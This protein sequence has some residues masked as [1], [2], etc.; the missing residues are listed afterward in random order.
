[1]PFR[2]VGVLGSGHIPTYR[3]N[4]LISLAPKQLVALLAAAGRELFWGL[5]AVSREIDF[6]RRRAHAIPN[7]SLRECAVNSITH[8]RDNAE[9]AALFWILPRRRNLRLLRLLVAYQTIWD[10]LDNAT[11][12]NVNQADTRQMHLA[13]VEALD[14]ESAI[15]DYY[16]YRHGQCDG[17]YLQALVEACR[18]GCATL[19]SYPAVRSR[20]LAGVQ[21]C[22]IQGINHDP[23]PRRRDTELREW[24]KRESAGQP[25]IAWFEFAAAASAFLP[26]VLLALAG[27]S[28]CTEREMD[29]ALAAYFP[30]VSLTIA[31]L[32]SYA[33]RLEDIRSG[34][35][36]YVAHYT[37]SEAA[38]QRI[39]EIVHRTA[40]GVRELHNGTRHAILVACMFAMHLSREGAHAT[41]T[42]A[43]TRAIA[44][45]GGSLTRLLLP[46]V[47]AWRSVYLRRVS[48][49]HRSPV[50][51]RRQPSTARSAL[52]PGSRLPRPIQT[53]VTWRWPH[54]RLTR[55][56][57]RYGNR[58]TLN[59]TSHPPLVFLSDPQDIQ[60]MFAAPADVLHPGEGVD[61]IEP[62]VG[63]TSFMLSDEEEHLSGR[64][65]ILPPFRPR[66]VAQ[67]EGLIA[68]IVSRETSSWPVDT[69]IAL[70]QRLRGLT[71]RTLLRTT[72]QGTHFAAG[73]AADRRLD[74][75]HE[76]LLQMLSITACAVFPEPLLRRGPGRR[77]WERFLRERE[78]V[79]QLIY[80]MVAARGRQTG[81]RGESRSL[82]STPGP[83]SGDLLDRLMQARNADGSLASARQV[84]DNLMSLILAGHETTA[85][86]LAWAFQLLAHN[87]RV[88]RRLIEEIDLGVGDAYLTATVQEVLRHRPVFLFAIPR[89]IKQPIEIGGWTYRPPAQLLACTYLLHHDPSIYPDPD[90]FRPERFLEGQ[91]AP[92]TWMPWGGGRK[93]CPGSHL[94]MLEMKIVLRT[95][96]ERMT[97]DP[98][99]PRM[100]RPRW[101]SVIVTPHAGGRVV[102]RKR[103]PHRIVSRRLIPARVPAQAGDNRVSAYD[104]CPAHGLKTTNGPTEPNADLSRNI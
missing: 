45:S 99:S 92:D 52:P 71:L 22:A 19:P 82:D 3:N 77:R 13:L 41:S 84:R 31:M 79:D 2:P 12:S 75:L 9:G 21:M 68:E 48:P 10:Y 43:Q 5:G 89:T 73:E 60:A 72:F 40:V 35:H 30:W 46:I 94:A 76:E 51:I 54:A 93:R 87:P 24:A 53:Y 101:R 80:A 17:G 28:Q 103:Q 27:E 59:K 4:D 14:P 11:E 6:W 67:A 95:V 1:M 29:A 25:S 61:T 85:S 39:C 65:T 88:Q 32:D 70:H 83:G 50:E 33:D 49:E 104:G 90:E 78:E 42:R 34:E 15:S 91:P 58:F 37:S 26:H 18:E 47:K 44:A 86:Q 23:D 81:S 66:V 8:K 97:V 56:R 55:Y 69:S 63:E 100:E 16:R 20:V 64:K 38:I 74:A 102:L 57:H 98:A 62:L 36:S 7:R 96:L